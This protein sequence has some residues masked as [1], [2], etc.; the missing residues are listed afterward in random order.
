MEKETVKCEVIGRVENP[1]EKI[2]EDRSV[3]KELESKIIIKPGLEEG[4]YR[5]SESEYVDIIFNFHLSGE[6]SLKCKTPHWGIK[7]V[8]AC[9]SPKRPSRLGLTKVKL[10]ETG[11]NFIKVKGLD[12][13]SGT[14]VIDIKPSI[15]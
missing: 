13:V 3:F 6:Y 14:P 8:F 15:N 5:I 2:P 1:V 11:D 7:G 4:L 12:A 10:L 9:R